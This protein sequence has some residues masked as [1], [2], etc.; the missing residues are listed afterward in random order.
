MRITVFTA[1]L[2][3]LA[4]DVTAEPVKLKCVA[5]TGEAVADLMVDIEKREMIWGPIRHYRIAELTDE[6][7]TAIHLDDSGVGG[8]VWV[9]SRSS[10]EYRR[11]IVGLFCFGADCTRER[12]DIGTYRGTCQTNML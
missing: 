8:E 4:G 7:V 9:M 5:D 11:A 3:I 12:L 6:Y 1:F 2:R 10:G